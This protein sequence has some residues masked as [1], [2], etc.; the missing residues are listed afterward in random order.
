MVEQAARSAILS[1]CGRYRYSLTRQWRAAGQ[2][3]LWVMLN[4]STA[5]ATHDD[6]TIRAI[7]RITQAWGYRG[8]MVGNVYALR[9]RN[10]A[11]LWAVDDP[12]GPDN[13]RHL[14]DM[15]VSAHRI[16]AAWGAH[17]DRADA[18]PIADMLAIYGDV[19][20]LG[21]NKN[22]SPKHPL[23]LRTDTERVIFAPH[24][25]VA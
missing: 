19:W 22:G 6:N 24:R 11:A 12:V 18:D 21:L 17:A 14:H 23:F 20:C 8:F 16:I 9:S 1:P 13:A 5:D 7:T 3:A 25:R 2:T 10:P 4:P 15:A